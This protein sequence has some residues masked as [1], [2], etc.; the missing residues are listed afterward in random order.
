[1]DSDTE[2]PSGQ[3]LNSESQKP[4][5]KVKL[6]YDAPLPLPHTENDLQ[7]KRQRQL[8]QSCLHSRT[9][10][11]SAGEN[12]GGKGCFASQLLDQTRNLLFSVYSTHTD[13]WFIICS[14]VYIGRSLG[15]SIPFPSSYGTQ[16]GLQVL[17]QKTEDGALPGK[18]IW[19]KHTW[20]DSRQCNILAYVQP[21]KAVMLTLCSLK[22]LFLAIF[23]ISLARNL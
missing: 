21:A 19:G 11:Q 16:W 6:K 8:Q 9:L 13:G 4:R 7:D 17:L 2:G 18:L 10:G 15:F 1:M 23:Y 22:I 12:W 20:A 3:G 14:L 5:E